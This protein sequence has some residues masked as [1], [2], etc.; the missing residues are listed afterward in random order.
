MFNRKKKNDGLS[1]AGLGAKPKGTPPKLE[2]PYKKMKKGH[3][4]DTKENKTAE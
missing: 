1:Y 4:A 3:S 2:S